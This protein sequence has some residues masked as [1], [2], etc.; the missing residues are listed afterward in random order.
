MK[1][2]IIVVIS[3]SYILIE[4]EETTSASLLDASRSTQ[5]IKQEPT[6]PQ[7]ESI[8]DTAQFS[9]WKPSRIKIE[10]YPSCSS[11]LGG[12]LEILRCQSSQLL[13]GASYFGYQGKTENVVGLNHVE[14]P[15][16]EQRSQSEE[17][18]EYEFV[19][20]DNPREIKYE[21]QESTPSIYSDPI[22]TSEEQ[23]S[24]LGTQKVSENSSLEGD[25]R[26]QNEDCT[27]FYECS[28]CQRTFKSGHGLMLHER[29][30]HPHESLSCSICSK[31]FTRGRSF[32]KHIK[33][34]EGRNNIL[35][36]HSCTICNKDFASRQ[37]LNL[38]FK[39]SENAERCSC[40]IC[41]KEFCLNRDLITHKRIDHPRESTE[42]YM[43]HFCKLCGKKFNQRSNLIKHQ[44]VHLGQELYSCGVCSRKFE[45]NSCSTKHIKMHSDGSQSQK[46][47]SGAE[48]YSCRTCRKEYDSVYDLKNHRLRMH[49]DVVPHSSR[50]YE[51]T[52]KK[53]CCILINLSVGDIRQECD[54]ALGGS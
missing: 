53:D 41:G 3:A 28:L 1:F 32:R 6:S 13:D 47:N 46:Q 7:H 20:L 33:F 54:G 29:R 21:A 22:E 30:K 9:C 42:K 18:V 14:P 38:H 34:H 43:K 4:A 5:R 49:P 24:I 40:E 52:V 51:E 50:M 12:S 17:P 36:H 2:I 11:S 15:E 8:D 44:K 45:H 23:A 27:R 16:A 19:S 35:G 39:K 25:Q 31:R 48:P 26:R 37:G 10:E